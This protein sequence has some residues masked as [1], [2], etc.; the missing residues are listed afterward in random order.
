MQDEAEQKA[1]NRQGAG[2]MS[3]EYADESQ[4]AENLTVPMEERSL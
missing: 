4:K 3:F 1:K 2:K